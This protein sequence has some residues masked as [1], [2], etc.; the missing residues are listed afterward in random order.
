MAASGANAYG[1]FEN[2]A[3]QSE[4][5]VIMKITFK[6]G[7]GFDGGNYLQDGLL[8]IEDLSGWRTVAPVAGIAGCRA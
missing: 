8:T 3:F 1:V 2:A 7:L 6:F 5:G 4:N